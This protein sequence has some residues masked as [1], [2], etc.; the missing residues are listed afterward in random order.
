MN[1][2]ITGLRRAV[3][4]AFRNHQ[5]TVDESR[6]SEMIQF[7]GFIPLDSQPPGK[8]GGDTAAYGNPQ[9]VDLVDRKAVE[10]RLQ[11]N[12]EHINSI[13]GEEDFSYA[14]TAS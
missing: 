12:I 1:I 2:S 5:L 8:I 9:L 11:Q 13:G 6:L 3:R 10:Q 14:K 4:E 7:L